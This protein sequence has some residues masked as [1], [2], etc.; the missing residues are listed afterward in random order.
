[1]STARRLGLVLA[2][3]ALPTL[4]L[5]LDPAD[6]AE[7]Y[8]VGAITIID[9]WAKTTI[10]GSHEVKLF[11]EFRNGSDAPDRLVGVT[12][13]LAT[14]PSRFRVVEVVDGERRVRDLKAIELPN[15]DTSFELTE[16]GYYLELT[17]LQK[18]ILMG[19]RFLVELIFE[20]AGRL[21][22][23][24]TARFHSP[25]LTRRIREAAKRGDLEMLKELNIP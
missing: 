15:S 22:V 10:G 13:L 19:K 3:I 14:G 21:T 1:M 20:R 2:L 11:F 6:Q 8:Q 17:G 12:S 24:F 18:P 9:P 5:E 23:E 25:K 4:G 16:V 7:V